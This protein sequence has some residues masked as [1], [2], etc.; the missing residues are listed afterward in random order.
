MG[1]PRGD[2]GGNGRLVMRKPAEKKS[3]PKLQTFVPEPSGFISIY[4]RMKQLRNPDLTKHQKAQVSNLMS[5]KSNQRSECLFANAFDVAVEMEE[6]RKELETETDEK[7]RKRINRKLRGLENKITPAV[8]RAA[9]AR[10]P[11]LVPLVLQYF[12]QQNGDTN[13]SRCIKW[14]R[15]HGAGK[16]MQDAAM[17]A[18]IKKVFGIVGQRGRPRGS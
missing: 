18:R 9:I 14:V 16:S 6:L 7:E 8:K 11:M 2:A 17:R 12:R 10:E 3:D 15:D 4:G 13:I 5:A 1:K